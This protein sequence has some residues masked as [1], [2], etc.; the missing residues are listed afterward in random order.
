M[1]LEG[2]VLNVLCLNPILD[3]TSLCLEWRKPFDVLADST[4][5]AVGIPTALWAEP[6]E[7]RESVG[8]PRGL[9]TGSPPQQVVSLNFAKCQPA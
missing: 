9:W 7:W 1:R 2:N 3:S 8:S 4:K 5:T 6:H